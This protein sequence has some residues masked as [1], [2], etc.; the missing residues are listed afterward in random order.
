MPRDVSLSD[1]KCWN[2]GDEWVKLLNKFHLSVGGSHKVGVVSMGVEEASAS[3]DIGTH[4]NPP[5]LLLPG[6]CLLANS[7][8]A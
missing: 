1:S 8:C 2:G 4:H 7:L 6:K 5:L 3:T